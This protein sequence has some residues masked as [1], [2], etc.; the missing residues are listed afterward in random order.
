MALENLDV[1]D[2]AVGA[3]KVKPETTP[4]RKLYKTTK[5]HARCMK[6]YHKY[7]ES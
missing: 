1:N 7:S 2:T 4:I 3:R 6:T 5:T